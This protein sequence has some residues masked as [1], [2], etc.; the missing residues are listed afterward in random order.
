ML[1]IGELT[2]VCAYSPKFVLKSHADSRIGVSAN[3][4][5]LL[6]PS[7]PNLSRARYPDLGLAAEE[8]SA[9][10]SPDCSFFHPKSGQ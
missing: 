10:Q 8:K 4:T 5:N 1:R 7:Y 9:V 6:K 3:C 2:R